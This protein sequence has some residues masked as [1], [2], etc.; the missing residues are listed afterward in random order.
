MTHS[1]RA[2]SAWNKNPLYR[3]VRYVE[4][5]IGRDTVNTITSATL[6]SLERAGISLVKVT[7]Q[8]LEEGVTLFHRGFDSLLAAVDAGRGSQVAS[9]ARGA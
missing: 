3:D 1:A 6:E 8:L 4:E 9:S 5:L 2:A 7:D